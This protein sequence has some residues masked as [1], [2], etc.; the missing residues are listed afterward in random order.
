MDLG[1]D[2]RVALVTG[3]DSGIGFH[4]AKR[5]LE[6]GATVVFTD[7]FQD[8]LDH[9][10]TEL[11]RGATQPSACCADVTDLA[12]LERL[13]EFVERATGGI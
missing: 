7:Q 4:T 9:A 11:A 3:A 10:A 12:S 8:H 6:E 2:G 5:L 13:R 1:L